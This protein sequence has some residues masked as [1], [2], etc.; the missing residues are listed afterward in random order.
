MRSVRIADRLSKGWQL[1]VS[2]VAVSMFLGPCVTHLLEWASLAATGWGDQQLGPACDCLG[3]AFGDFQWLA[4]AD[5]PQNTLGLVPNPG[6]IGAKCYLK[7]IMP[8]L[9]TPY[10]SVF[11][12]DSLGI[13]L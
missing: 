3:G 8:I 11:S 13:D 5:P 10:C 9:R 2:R 1:L 7:F 4:L 6:K 12:K